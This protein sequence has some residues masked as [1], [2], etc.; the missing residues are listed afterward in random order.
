MTAPSEEPASAGTGNERVDAAIERLR[1]LDSASIDAHAEV[2]EAVHEEL[3][4]ALTAAGAEGS[5]AD[6]ETQ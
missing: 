3:R 6:H 1:E 2:Y 4:A 5:P